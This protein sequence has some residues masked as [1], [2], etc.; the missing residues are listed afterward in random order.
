MLNGTKHTSLLSGSEEY[1]GTAIWGCIFSH[2]RPSY[3]WA[4]SDLDP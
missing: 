3:E 4:V 2:V 1:Y